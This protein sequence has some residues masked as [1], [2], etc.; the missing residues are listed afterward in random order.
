MTSRNC[1]ARPRS[2][3]P[4][5]PS[6]PARRRLRRA[7]CSG[8]RRSPARALERRRWRAARN[9]S[10]GRASS[11]GRDD[12]RS[13]SR[14]RSRDRRATRARRR[15]RSPRSSTGCAIPTRSM[16]GTCSACV[17]SIRSTRRRA[18]ATAASSSTARSASSPSLPGPTAGRSARRAAARWARSILR[19]WRIFPRRARSGGRASCA[20]RAGSLIRERR[21]APHVADAARRDPRQAR[22]SRSASGRS[23]CTRAPTAS[24][25]CTDGRY[26]ILDYKTGQAPTAAQVRSGL[27]PQLTL[28]GAILRAGGFENMPAEARS[29]NSCTCR[30][31]AASRPANRRRSPGTIHAGYAKPTRRCGA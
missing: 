27:A 16:R 25:I 29:R 21:A 4:A 30:C 13:R 7:S 2:C 26:A 28:E 1:S 31:A 15:S 18:R 20:S 10:P 5:P 23:R 12:S 9:I 17:R 11:T 8:S 19:R 22:R 24:S 6:S 14:G 3:S